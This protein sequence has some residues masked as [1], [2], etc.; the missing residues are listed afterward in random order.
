MVLGCQN[1]YMLL[2]LIV[3]NISPP[4]VTS[5]KKGTFL[6]QLP[7]VYLCT[8]RHWFCTGGKGESLPPPPP[9]LRRTYMAL[10]WTWIVSTLTFFFESLPVSLF[11][12]GVLF[13]VECRLC[14]LIVNLANTHKGFSDN[15]LTPQQFLFPRS[16][17]RSMHGVATWERLGVSVSNL[18]EDIHA[19]AVHMH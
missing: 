14:V 17:A 10:T 4:S 8:R 11:K 9:P 16:Y 18:C 12:L 5:L 7:Q 13:A 3:S 2:F 6:H 19:R 15:S 1:K